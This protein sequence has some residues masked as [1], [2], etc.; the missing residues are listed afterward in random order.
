MILQANLDEN[1]KIDFIIQTDDLINNF[2]AEALKLDVIQEEQFGYAGRAEQQIEIKINRVDLLLQNLKS[3][4]TINLNAEIKKY[5]D[6]K[7]DSIS[8]LLNA[9]NFTNETTL[10]LNINS[11]IKKEEIAVVKINSG[12]TILL[13]LKQTYYELKVSSKAEK[14]VKCDNENWI[15]AAKELED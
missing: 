4:D 2:Q 6:N 9:Y 1:K 10:N 15:E 11:N 5:L 13:K 14:L 8:N 12:K 7:T 3:T